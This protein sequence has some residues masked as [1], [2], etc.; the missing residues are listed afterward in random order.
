MNNFLYISNNFKY[1]FKHKDSSAPERT[2][3][4]HP[5]Q[6]V[7]SQFLQL[8]KLNEEY[9]RGTL[10]ELSQIDFQTLKGEM[11]VLV[12]GASETSG[13][14]TDEDIVK[15]LEF[16]LSKGISKKA[17]IEIVSDELKQ[18]K[19]KVYKIAQDM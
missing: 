15:R 12:A 16:C 9:I 6:N 14:T 8:T 2:D 19:N 3:R 13:E 7:W 11:V 1:P 10:N 4:L 17:A 5:I 18:P